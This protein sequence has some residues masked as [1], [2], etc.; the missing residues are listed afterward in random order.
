MDGGIP[1]SAE[2]AGKPVAMGA[3][4]MALARAFCG[5]QHKAHEGQPRPCFFWCPVAGAQSPALRG[6]F[7]IVHRLALA[8]G[9]REA[10]IVAPPPACDSAVAPCFH[11]SPVFL[12][13]H[14]LLWLSSL[15]SPQ[16]VSPQPTAVLTLG[17]F[18]S[19][20]APALSPLAH[21]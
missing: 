13:R 9:E 3:R 2:C 6:L 17:L 5:A 18:S 7:C 16:S 14:S 10:T 4:D 15:P 19:P 8:C 11:G 20:H 1:S 21:L 12:H